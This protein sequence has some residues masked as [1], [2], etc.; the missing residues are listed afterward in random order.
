[1]IF[2]IR[3]IAAVGARRTGPLAWV[4][5]NGTEVA[6][7]TGIPLVLLGFSTLMTHRAELTICDLSRL[8]S[9]I[10]GPL[11]ALFGDL[12]GHRAVHAEGARVKIKVRGTRETVVA[13]R[14]ISA[15]FGLRPCTINETELPWIAQVL[16]SSNTEASSRAPI[17]GT[18]LSAGRAEEPVW[19][20]LAGAVAPV[21]VGAFRAYVQ[22][23]RVTWIGI[24]SEASRDGLAV[25]EPGA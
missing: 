13:S 20:G 17:V 9:V 21:T 4:R 10:E 23:G 2:K 1:L 19:A 8:K 7:R 11:R 18:H 15:A 24:G 25:L 6:L 12:S 14:A 5:A 3:P 22:D 16:Y